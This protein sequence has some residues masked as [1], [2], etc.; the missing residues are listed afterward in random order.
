M[1]LFELTKALMSIPSTSGEEEAVG[2]FLGDHLRSLGWTVELQEAGAATLSPGARTLSSSS[3]EDKSMGTGARTLSS[4]SKEDKQMGTGVSPLR[5]EKEQMGTGVS[6]LRQFNVIATLNDTPRVW[7]S[8]H[9]DTVPPYIPPTEDDERIYGRGAC[10]AKGIIASQI[11]AAERLRAEGVEDIGLLFT[12]EEER[13]STGAKAANLHP[14]AAKCEYLINGEPTDNELAIGS[15]GTFRLNIKTAGKAA[16][17]AYPEEG[18]SAIEKLLDILEDVRHT[19][20]PNDEFFGETTVNI[21]TIEGGLALNVIAPAAEAGLAIR[22]TTK[23][24]PIEDAIRNI[25]RD[26]GEVEVLSASEPVK[27]LAVDGFKQ[28]VVRFTTDIPHLP[29]WGQPLLIGPGSIL[30][31]HTKDEFVLKKD[32]ETAVDLY[33]DLAKALLAR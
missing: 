22:L 32:L 12:V 33:V 20:L 25:V 27:M 23:R 1:N 29:N 13:A 7:L 18:E 11:T 21:G 24:E 8:T 9:M 17:S 2:V 15:K 31:A 6:P 4:S 28:K 16:H 5:A 19:R 14:L 30:V 26:R 10:D 3:K